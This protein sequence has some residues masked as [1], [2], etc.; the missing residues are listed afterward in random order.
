MTRHG[1]LPPVR[2]VP[3]SHAKGRAITAATFWGTRPVLPGSSL[4]RTQM[5]GDLRL[6]DRGRTPMN[7]TSDVA[8]SQWNSVQPPQEITGRL[9]NWGRDITRTHPLATDMLL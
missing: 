4:R 3:G 8:G 2:G 6:S 5:T 1:L 7:I 9:F